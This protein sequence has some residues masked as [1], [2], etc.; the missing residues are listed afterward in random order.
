MDEAWLGLVVEEANLSVQISTIRRA[1]AQARASIGEIAY[2]K[3]LSEA[4]SRPKAT[5]LQSRLCPFRRQLPRRESRRFRRSDARLSRR[6]SHCVAH[7][8]FL[9]VELAFDASPCLVGDAIL[10]V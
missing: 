2:G 4:W 6:Q 9:E 8:R 7:A 3:T 1:L 5:R 10:L